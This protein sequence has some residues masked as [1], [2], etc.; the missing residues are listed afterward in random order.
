MRV[1]MVAQPC[2]IMLFASEANSRNYV[3]TLIHLDFVI[4]NNDR[5]AQNFYG[6]LV[7]IVV[8]R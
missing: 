3:W 6:H 7:F 2:N 1:F 5:M 4:F 8:E